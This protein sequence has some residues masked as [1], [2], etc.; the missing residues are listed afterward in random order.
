M[1]DLGVIAKND[2]MTI[3]PGKFLGRPIPKSREIVDVTKNRPP[4][5]RG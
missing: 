4:L 3:G 2:G 5:T 1:F